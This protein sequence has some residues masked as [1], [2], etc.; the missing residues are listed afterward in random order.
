[1]SDN[2]LPLPT[3]EKKVGR[4]K[5]WIY[6]AVDKREFPRPVKQGRENFW[7]ESEID[8]YISGLVVVRDLENV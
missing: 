4:K 3:V 2:L 1:M 6:A 5:S 7:L 8:N